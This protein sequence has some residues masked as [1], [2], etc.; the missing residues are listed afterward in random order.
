MNH[1]PVQLLKVTVRTLVVRAAALHPSL[2]AFMLQYMQHLNFLFVVEFEVVIGSC[3]RQR[4]KVTR[5][6][7]SVSGESDLLCSSCLDS[8]SR[9][10]ISGEASHELSTGYFTQI[11]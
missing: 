9:L 2:F 5:L 11:Y 7:F 4:R 6:R 1:L 3:C 8:F 10:D